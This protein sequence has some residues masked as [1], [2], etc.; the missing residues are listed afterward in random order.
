MRLSPACV[1]ASWTVLAAC[2][3]AAAAS[4]SASGSISTVAG[5]GEPGSLSTGAA[6]T[7]RLNGPS[8]VAALG[9]G[10]FLIADT[11]NGRIRSVRPSGA[12]STLPAGTTPS[13]ATALVSPVG[14]AT[15]PDGAVLV[16]DGHRLLRIADGTVTRLAGDSSPGTGGDGGAASSARFDAPAG[17]AVLPSGGVLVA[18]M[19]NH[20]IRKLEGGKISTVAGRGTAGASGDGGAAVD[21]ELRTPADVAV[22]PDGDLLIADTGNDRVRRVD[23][24]TGLISTV[25]GGGAD[26]ADGVPATDAALPQPRSVA[27]AADGSFAVSVAGSRRVRRVAADATITTIAGTGGAGSTGDGGPGTAATLDAPSG[28]SV[29]AGGRL[30]IADP[31]GHRIRALDAGLPQS[32]EQPTLDDRPPFDAQPPSGAQPPSDGQPP[33]DAQPPVDEAG[34][35]GDPAA[36]DPSPSQ[37]AIGGRA[38][39]LPAPGPAGPAAAPAVPV[40]GRAVV[41]APVSG[42]VLVR[43]PGAQTA[44]PLGSGD[45]V[46]VGSL[47]DARRGTVALTSALPGGRTQTGRFSGGRFSVAQPARSG[48]TELTLRGPELESCRPSSPGTARAAARRKPVRRL[49][50]EDKGGRF[51]TRGRNSVATVRGTRWLTEDTCA[52]TLTRVVEGAVDVTDPRRK[53][54]RRV[55]AGGSLLVRPAG[56]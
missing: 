15:A 37:P 42:T 53:V 35:P 38:D 16:T 18:D 20:R 21:A 10:G 55:R 12:I 11:L 49:W 13:A 2:A 1:A 23:D 17:V 3:T 22:L 19:G 29:G 50:G 39:A 33:L 27:P 26:A 40:L 45:D 6:T 9:D 44:R 56:G 51:R 54:T 24:A 4:A 48:M 7:S 34:A 52:G 32:G 28:L 5:T 14:L 25:A 31:A 41:V 47:V 46:P 8:D 43:R 36:A 30:L